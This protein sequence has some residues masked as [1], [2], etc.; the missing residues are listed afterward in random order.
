MAQPAHPQPQDD[1]PF[2]LPR[3]ILTMTAATITTKT[4]LIII[5]DIFSAIHVSIENPPVFYIAWQPKKFGLPRMISY[6][7]TFSF[8]FAVSFV[9]SL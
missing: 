8:I 1:F 3:I 4:T 7:A 5:V 9:A 6:F 2:F